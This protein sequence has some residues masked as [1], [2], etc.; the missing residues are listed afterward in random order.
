[1]DGNTITRFFGGSPAGVLIRL[2]AISFVVGVV[3]SA[4]GLSPIDIVEGLRDLVWRIYSLGFDSVEWIVR[5]F[6]LGAVI[7]FPIWLIS[8]LL[9]VGRRPTPLVRTAPGSHETVIP[10]RR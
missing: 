5:Y 10:P 7:V 1:M 9:K 6:L 8:R 2:I 4:L 3:L